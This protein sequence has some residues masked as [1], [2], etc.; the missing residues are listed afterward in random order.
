[1]TRFKE[2]SELTTMHAGLFSEAAVGKQVVVTGD[3][4][5]HTII[6]VSMYGATL[7]PYRWW[8]RLY[9]SRLVRWLFL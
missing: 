2:T 3:P 8:H 4:R 1:M 9:R 6:R 7:A 5:P